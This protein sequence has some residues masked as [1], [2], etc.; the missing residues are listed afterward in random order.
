MKY[1]LTIDGNR[2]LIG[3]DQN[4]T[5][6]TLKNNKKNPFSSE[7]KEFTGKVVIQDQTELGQVMHELNKDIL[8]TD[9]G[10]LSIDKRS[11]LTNVEVPAHT[12]YDMLAH[13]HFL[14]M[15]S[16]ALTMTHK[17][18]VISRDG[19]GREEIRDIAIGRE[20]LRGNGGFFDRLKNVFTGGEK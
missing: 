1:I 7:K 14:P 12:Q 9:G 16:L 20:Q 6:L 5:D 17:R 8:E 3:E 15:D 2:I 4:D 10:G 11:R 19:K 18:L 13:F